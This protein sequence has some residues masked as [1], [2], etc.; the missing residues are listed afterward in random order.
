MKK[1]RV[2]ITGAGGVGTFSIYRKLKKKYDFYFV[3]NNLQNVHPLIPKNK[4]FKVP[5]AVYKK[6]YITKIKFLIQKL[7]IDLI[8][9]TVDEELNIFSKKYKNIAL[10]PNNKFVNIFNNKLKTYLS[11]QNNKINQPKIVNHREL[12]VKKTYPI[13]AKPILGR[14]SRGI[15]KVDN[16][17]E[18]I[19]YKDKFNIDSKNYILQKF[20]TGIEYSVQ[21]I[22]DKN[23]KLITVIPVKIIEKKGITVNAIISKNRSVIKFCKNFHNIYM[24]ELVYNIQLMV[25]LQGIYI[26]EINPRVS[27]THILT[28]LSGIDPIK[29]FFS[30]KSSKYLNLNLKP[31]KLIRYYDTFF[32]D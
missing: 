24:P 2:L 29:I 28:L 5:L 32:N 9:P 13:I 14:G 30:K 11:L 25:N 22:A 27:T 3:D 7:K 8:I 1:N 19:F 16:L 15:I 18:F 23:G 21:M 31:I 4:S 26:I 17:K 12:K 20:I 10:V 6:K